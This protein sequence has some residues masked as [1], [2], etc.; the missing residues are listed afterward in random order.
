[1]TQRREVGQLIDV[2]TIYLEPAVYDYERGRAVLARFPEAERIEVASHWQIPALHGNAQLSEAWL[3]VKQHTLVLGVK[4]GLSMRPNGR[5]A[6]FIA[7]SQANGCALSCAYCVAAGTLIATPRGPI[8][9]E[10]IQ[11]GDEVFAYD[12][13]LGLRVVARVFGTA[14]RGVD[15]V[16]EIQ[17]GDTILRVTAEH[18]LMT[19]RGWVAAGDLT[20]DDEVLCDDDHTE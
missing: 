17:V 14:A 3:R 15:E 12:S 20:E 7:P 1:M 5:S 10:Q 6:D 4:K 2:D 16:L 8:P 18:P 19:R 11:D 13:S 9:V